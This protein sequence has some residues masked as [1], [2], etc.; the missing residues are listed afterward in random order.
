[1]ADT[2]LVGRF[3]AAMAV[4]GPFECAPRLAAG[5]SGGADS[6]ALALLAD[7]WARERGGTLQAL[8]VDHGLRAESAAEA[9][10]TVSRLTGLGIASRLLTIADLVEG[11]AMA[12]RARDARYRV[13]TDA[14]RRDGRMHLLLGHHAADQAETMM[15]RVLSGSGVSGLAGMPAVAEVESLRV[16]RPLLM[17]PP[18]CLRAYLSREGMTW[19]EDPS[20]RDRHALRAR[21][22]FLRADPGG[23]GAGTK[24]L[25]GAARLAGSRRSAD[26]AVVARVLAAQAVIRPEG[27]ALLSPAPVPPEAW[28]VLLRTISGAPFAPGM[29][30]VAALAADPRPQTMWGVRILPAGRLGPG[31]LLVRE[32]VAAAPPVLATDGAIWDGRFRLR[33]PRP[34]PEGTYV[35]AL[36]GAASMVRRQSD[37]P[38]AVLR[39]MPALWRRNVLVAVPHLLYPDAKICNGECSPVFNPPRPLTSANFLPA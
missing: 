10:A 22:R 1:M 27:F 35:G 21:L 8:V 30:Q 11:P 15:I 13:L 7:A 6:M 20:N 34:L 17:V 3:G 31:W 26:D 2:G 38:A 33:A 14:C 12:A 5:V 16:L 39:V 23:D 9:T 36:G 37:L 32:E 24:A 18:A 19:V 4:L 28:A 29:D 25:V